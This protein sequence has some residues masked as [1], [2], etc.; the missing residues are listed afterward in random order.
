MS[1]RPQ[2]CGSCDWEYV[3]KLKG[4]ALILSRVGTKGDFF[5][6]L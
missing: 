2:S 3:E 4:Q 5:G 1:Y 6:N